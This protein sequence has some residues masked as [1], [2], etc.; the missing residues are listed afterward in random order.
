MTH[1]ALDA[2]CEGEQD[3]YTGTDL[4]WFVPY[5]VFVSFGELYESLKS[6]LQKNFS[7]TIVTLH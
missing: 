2:D 1:K 5:S 6:T 4:I 7:I 3:E